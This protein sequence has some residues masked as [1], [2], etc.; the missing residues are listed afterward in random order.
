MTSLTLVDSHFRFGENWAEFAQSIDATRIDQAERD[1]ARLLGTRDLTGLR[2]LDIGSGSGLHSLAALRLGASCVTAIDLDPQSVATTRR[3][4]TEFATGMPWTAELRSVFELEPHNFGRF[5]IVYSWGVLHHTGAMREAIRK[6]AALVGDGGRLG[7]ALYGRTALC[8]FWRAEKRLYSRSPKALQSV[9]RGLY[10]TAYRLV[11][12][13]RAARRGRRFDFRE[14]ASKYHER[15]GMN[16]HNDVHDWLGGYPYESIAPHELRT[17]LRE[18]GFSETRSFIQPGRRDGLLG[19][20]CD[21][22]VFE[23]ISG[24]VPI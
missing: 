17:F 3:L 19:A 14:Y 15:R 10:V 1:L 9:M 13:A 4:L 24:T 8:G 16:F 23:R 20:G 2:F 6:A 18:L 21:E 22:Y 12:W 11:Q 5:D 7:V